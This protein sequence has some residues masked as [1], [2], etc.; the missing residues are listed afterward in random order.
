MV[1]LARRVAAYLDADLPVAGRFALVCRDTRLEVYRAVLWRRGVVHAHE[2]D[3][4]AAWRA[5]GAQYTKFTRMARVELCPTE[6]A[7]FVWSDIAV[8]PEFGVTIE[9][10]D[11]LL[12]YGRQKVT[13]VAR[14][15][16]VVVADR[17]LTQIRHVE[18]D[19]KAVGEYGSLK[20]TRWFT[21]AWARVRDLEAYVDVLIYPR[22]KQRS[23]LIDEWIRSTNDAQWY[24]RWR[25]P[26]VRRL[27]W[28]SSAPRTPLKACASDLVVSKHLEAA[29]I[30]TNDEYIAGSS[31][32]LLVGVEATRV[33]CYYARDEI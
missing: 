25:T 27:S 16:A 3:W 19:P 24:C 14:D 7:G 6:D 10:A 23:R 18:L 17:L 29:H 31:W 13:A 15:P 22:S 9:R 21:R 2:S 28:P 8:L 32:S 33:S 12:M 4:D 30:H 20:S 1:E 26:G 11:G 5:Y